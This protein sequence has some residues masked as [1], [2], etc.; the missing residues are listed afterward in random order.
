MVAVA[1]VMK[2]GAMSD[3]LKVLQVVVAVVAV[4]SNSSGAASKSCSDGESRNGGGL[5]G[6]M[7]KVT[8]IER[9]DALQ[10]LRARGGR[11]T[12]PVDLRSRQGHNS[13]ARS[14]TSWTITPVRLRLRTGTKGGHC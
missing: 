12:A 13:M 6:V 1:G 14:H 8:C 3:M 9:S 5:G 11:P 4:A 10:H 7:V 2:A